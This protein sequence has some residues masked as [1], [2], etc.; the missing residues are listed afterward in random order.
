LQLK[1]AVREAEE[2]AMRMHPKYR[3]AL[4]EEKIHV[5]LQADT[6]EGLGLDSDEK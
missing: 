3:D 5:I 2:E 1:V 6:L 4:T